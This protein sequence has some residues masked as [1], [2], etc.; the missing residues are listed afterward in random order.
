MSV[1]EFHGSKAALFIG[2]RLLV[3]LRDDRPDIPYPNH[4]DFPG[5]GR[6]GA[7]T[8]E[9]TLRR[10]VDEEFGLSVPEAAIRWRRAFPAMHDPAARVWFFVLRYPEGTEG[11]VRFG[12]E[13]QEWRLMSWERFAMQ[14]RTV[15][16]FAD[17]MAQWFATGGRP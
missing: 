9:E 13:G 7:E 3:Y 15:P 2:R 8:P 1:D 11:Q 10:E 17:R 5:G 12:T 16:V 4:W 14:P 6:E